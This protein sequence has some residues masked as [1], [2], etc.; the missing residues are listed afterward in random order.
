MNDYQLYL[1]ARQRID[2]LQRIDHLHAEAMALDHGPGVPCR[3]AD[4][5]RALADW[6]RI[7]G[8]VRWPIAAAAV[9]TVFAV[10][11]WAPAWAQVP[12]PASP[13][14]TWEMMGADSEV[15]RPRLQGY[16]L[17][18]GDFTIYDPFSEMAAKVSAVHS[19]CNDVAPR[20]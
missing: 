16:L 6:M 14:K 10:V 2:Q 11:V 17:D 3:L 12:A 20:R 19:C 7:P 15:R 18:N 13:E 9:F 5:L 4:S 1:L 8:L